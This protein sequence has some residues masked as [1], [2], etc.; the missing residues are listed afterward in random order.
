MVFKSIFNELYDRF[1]F[2]VFFYLKM[3]CT[4]KNAPFSINV[5]YSCYKN[6]LIIYIIIIRRVFSIM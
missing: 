1:T 3:K 4:Y 5:N 2:Q 6:E